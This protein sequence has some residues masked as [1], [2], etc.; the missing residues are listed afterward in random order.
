MGNERFGVQTRDVDSRSAQLTEVLIIAV[1]RLDYASIV[2]CRL[3]Q[4]AVV[5]DD[6]Y[7]KQA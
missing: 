6:A 2:I 3:S 1:H 5:Q 4:C 7:E